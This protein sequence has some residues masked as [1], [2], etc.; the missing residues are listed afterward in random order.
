M[1]LP[2]DMVDVLEVYRTKGKATDK[3]VTEELFQHMSVVQPKIT[4][5]VQLKLLEQ[6][7]DVFDAED[8]KIYRQCRVRRDLQHR[9]PKMEAYKILYNEWVRCKECSLHEGREGKVVFGKGNLNADVFIIGNAPGRVEER[10][11][12][13]F[14]G[15]AGRA[16][17]RWMHRYRFDC[18]AKGNTF[19][20]NA[21]GCRNKMVVGEGIVTA[22]PE[23]AHLQACRSRLE[24]LLDL[25]YP[26]VVIITGDDVCS[27]LFHRPPKSMPVF[28]HGVAF[29]KT[30]DLSL[31]DPE[32]DNQKALHQIGT[33]EWGTIRE[34]YDRITQ[35]GTEP[36]IVWKLPLPLKDK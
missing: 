1:K 34:C 24:A 13:P 27:V 16:L 4:T 36:A 26:K 6:V 11:G 33:A 2:K 8:I 12:L 29:F 25:I 15:A 20:T 18:S 32:N 19:V 7:E 22:V 35:S 5:L 3:E 10:T 28:M 31:Y 30:Q 21:V 17:E 23:K 9:P 14:T